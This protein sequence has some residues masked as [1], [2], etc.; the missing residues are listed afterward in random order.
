MGL[1][2]GC[3]ESGAEVPW[4]AYHQQ[5]VEDLQ[6]PPLE[7]HTPSNIGAFPSRKARLFSIAE[8]RESLP[9]VYALRECRITSLVAARNNQLGRMA[10][11]S[12]RWLYERELWQRLSGCWNTAIPDTLSEE[13]RSRLH[14]LTLHKT[15]QLPLVSWNTLFDSSEWEGSFSRASHAIDPEELGATSAHLEAVTYLHRMILHQFDR[16]WGQDSS[17]LEGHLQ[18]LQQRPLSAEIMRALLLATQRLEE[19]T[20]YLEQHGDK[21]ST[22]LTSWDASGLDSLAEHSRE[23]LKAVNT[24]FNAHPVTPPKALRDYRQRWLSLNSESAPWAAFQLARKQHQETR[25]HFSRCQS[26]NK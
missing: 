17:T 2:A 8:T 4:E 3:S 19:G 23:W 13:D 20:D 12:Q 6:G 18:T 22:C 11:P 7:R 26:R 21:H 1:L 25:A 24:L 15:Q 10:P 14:R 9:N 5:L 16:Q